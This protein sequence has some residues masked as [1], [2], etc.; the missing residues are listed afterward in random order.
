MCIVI[1]GDSYVRRLGD[2]LRWN[3][4]PNFN[5]RDERVVFIGVGGASV[6]GRKRVI[7]QINEALGI[8]DVSLVY[9]H[10][11]S[12]D[13]ADR[14]YSPDDLAQD[15]RRLAAFVR[16]SSSQVQVIVGQ[17]H[18]RLSLPDAD[19]NRRV[20]HANNCLRFHLREMA[21]I[22]FLKIPGLIHPLPFIYSDGI[23][24]NNEGNRRF[25]RGIRGALIKVRDS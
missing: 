19:Y 10:I 9:I 23:H 15:I 13:L 5:L 7:H 2:Y 22:S 12:N 8:R 1:V 4:T 11:G 20:D 16:C 21:R 18:R 17:I 24:F 25:Y 14:S 6:R 3:G